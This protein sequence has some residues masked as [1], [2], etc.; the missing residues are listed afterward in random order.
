MNS[1][2][3]KKV[4]KKQKLKDSDSDVIEIERPKRYKV[5]CVQLSDT[6]ESGED[7]KNEPITDN[8]TSVSDSGGDSH[9]EEGDSDDSKK[10]KRHKKKSKRRFKL[11]FKEG[12]CNRGDVMGTEKGTKL[13]SKER[14]KHPDCG[15][16]EDIIDK[17]LPKVLDE[18][19]AKLAC[20]WLE[21]H[22]KDLATVGKAL[23][24][25]AERCLEK[26][27]SLKAM[28]N[29][30]NVDKVVNN[31]QLLMKLA[32][33][34]LE[35]IDGFLSLHHKYW[36]RRVIRHSST[37]RPANV[38]GCKQQDHDNNNKNS[39]TENNQGKEDVSVSMNGIGGKDLE[40]HSLTGNESDNGGNENRETGKQQSDILSAETRKGES[41]KRKLLEEGN[42]SDDREVVNSGENERYLQKSV[43][44][45]KKRKKLEDELEI[46]RVNVSSDMFVDSDV[47][48]AMNYTTTSENCKRE[49]DCAVNRS[50]KEE[51]DM[52]LED[53]LEEVA[54]KDTCTVK[55]Q[56]GGDTEI[57]KITV[58]DKNL[59]GDS[60]QKEEGNVTK[61]NTEDI[62]LQHETADR[63]DLS[64]TC[65]D[66]DDDDSTLYGVDRESVNSFESLTTVQL[67]VENH[68]EK[69][70]LSVEE[71]LQ[72]NQSRKSYEQ[73][74][75]KSNS[76]SE[77]EFTCLIKNEDGG[78]MAAVG[79]GSTNVENEKV[80]E[81]NSDT[82]AAT[83][84]CL[85]N[86]ESEKNH[87]SDDDG[88]KEEEQNSVESLAD[89]SKSNV[90]RNPEENKKIG[91]ELE[92]NE[93]PDDVEKNA[94]A[95]IGSD[96]VIMEGSKEGKGELEIQ[97]HTTEENTE[98]VEE[99]KMDPK[100]DPKGVIE[101]NDE[102]KEKLESDDEDKSSDIGKLELSNDIS[103]C[104]GKEE[105]SEKDKVEVNED[106]VGQEDEVE[107]ETM[108][109][110]ICTAESV[111]ALQALLEYT[112]DDEDSCMDTP[113]KKKRRKEQLKKENE[114][115][116]AV[117]EDSK[118][119]EKRTIGPK[120]RTCKGKKSSISSVSSASDTD[121]ECSTG[122][123][124]T[125]VNRVRKKKFNVKD[126]EAYKQDEKL[127][128]KCT[129]IVERLP[130]EVFQKHYER[131]YSDE[132]DETEKK[133]KD[134]KEIDR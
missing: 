65:N 70:V 42:D 50:S 31:L 108:N 74:Y 73:D 40:L 30:E 129:V 66:D 21:E 82:D 25:R 111:K 102:E 56:D 13:K 54:F 99:N 15:S 83:I 27:V 109:A 117:C 130:D 9:N 35:Q 92:S 114:K 85:F 104:E 79:E 94:L 133:A 72:G 58:K 10:K 119:A 16:A 127:G 20:D 93:V 110:S 49:G 34:N 116:V 118:P 106:K 124:I 67:S 131:Y 71:T 107:K 97:K 2:G 7:V 105:D 59:N 19:S 128:W 90:K 38:S 48:D 47:S 86:S 91:R 52:G 57:D 115:E 121:S 78:E 8:S 64:R 95:T 60:S 100:E 123:Q 80:S 37:K 41:K 96:D 14:M 112:A 12:R 63:L 36:V 23:A 69:S 5:E 17:K 55:T 120:S 51:T 125:K 126:T 22:S 32:G 53:V 81:K 122:R 18:T 88:N 101:K 3:G 4:D 6:E 76:E 89:D 132:E 44:R 26:E 134:D 77:G 75:K 68:L 46:G 29:P 98:G 87:S 45:D 28:T 43:I 1:D 61:K 33:E 84:E 62:S 113:R 103:D 39:I 11:T 24:L